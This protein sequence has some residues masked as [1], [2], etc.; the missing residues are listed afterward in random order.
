MFPVNSGQTTFQERDLLRASNNSRS[1]CI[2]DDRLRSTR[3]ELSGRGKG[4]RLPQ[5]SRY[6]SD[7]NSVGVKGTLLARSVMADSAPQSQGFKVLKKDPETL[8]SGLGIEDSFANSSIPTSL[9]T[10]SDVSS[11]SNSALDSDSDD[12]IEMDCVH[13]MRRAVTPDSVNSYLREEEEKY[14][15][16]IEEIKKQATERFKLSKGLESLLPNSDGDK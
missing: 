1:S 14:R 3:K 10:V 11:E 15:L 9:D 12:E 13:T 6:V 4:P 2:P 5:R 16:R 8:D 7:Y